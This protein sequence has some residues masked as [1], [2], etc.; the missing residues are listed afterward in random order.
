MSKTILLQGGPENGRIEQVPDD[1]EIFTI[2]RPVGPG[3]IIL[4]AFE[5]GYYEAT[6]LRDGGRQVF[7]WKGWEGEKN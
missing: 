2:T 6:R 1:L 7:K 3:K 5:K 4:L